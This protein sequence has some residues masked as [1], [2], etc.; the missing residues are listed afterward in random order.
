MRPNANPWLA[1]L[2]GVA[3]AA[4]AIAASE[5]LAGIV[6]GMPSLV[7]SLGDLVISLQPPGA[8]DL[9]VGLFGTNDKTALSI[10]IVVVALVVAAVAGILAAR[11]F[12]LGAA[13]FGIFGLVAFVAAARDPLGSPVAAAIAAGFALGAGLLTLSALIGRLP[14]RRAAAQGLAVSGGSAVASMPDW[15]RRRF[16]IAS[17]GTI[18]GAVV[19]GAVGRALI[20][21]N[22]P[23]GAVTSTRLPAP[24]SAVP[25]LATDESLAV[26][27]IT[28]IVVPNDEFYR[29]DTALLVPRVDVATWKLQI[30]GMVD[31]PLTFSL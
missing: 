23:T 4:V 22:H 14:D 17:A 13:V 28:P 5:L 25:A 27:G 26:D 31:H 11:Q 20:E 21:N 8:K 12:E 10:A 19:A 18:G 15:E 9:V 7:V 1:A 24:V 16:L 6:A 2:A 30:S 29:I 3:A